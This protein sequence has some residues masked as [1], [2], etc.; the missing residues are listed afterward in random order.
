[1]S[2]HLWWLHLGHGQWWHWHSSS[3]LMTSTVCMATRWSGLHHLSSGVKCTTSTAQVVLSMVLSWLM[4]ARCR[5]IGH[6]LVLELC[7]LLVQL[8]RL[9]LHG[10]VLGKLV[11]HRWRDRGLSPSRRV[12]VLGSGR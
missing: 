8:L 3:S 11:G 5:S 2:H 7:L 4:L 6:C 1:M 12:A 9:L 10:Q